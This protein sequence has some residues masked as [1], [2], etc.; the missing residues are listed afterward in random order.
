MIDA[1]S[2]MLL[3]NVLAAVISVP[4]LDLFSFYILLSALVATIAGA[5]YESEAT[6]RLG[7]DRLTTLRVRVGPRT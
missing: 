3:G 2:G 4:D 7:K 6:P 1:T 5:G